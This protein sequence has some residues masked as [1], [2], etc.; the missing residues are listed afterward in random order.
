MMSRT[1]DGQ[2]VEIAIC[3]RRDDAT[4]LH[5]VSALEWLLSKDQ[6]LCPS[7]E[8]RNSLSPLFQQQRPSWSTLEAEVKAA[9]NGIDDPGNDRRGR[10]L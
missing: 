1:R 8:L 4:Y 2:G 6:D 9:G 5:F 10:E 7:C 3:D